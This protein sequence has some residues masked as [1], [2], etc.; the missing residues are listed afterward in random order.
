MAISTEK[1][2]QYYLNLFPG[3][4]WLKCRWLQLGG[5]MQQGVLSMNQRSIGFHPSH[6]LLIYIML[7]SNVPH[8]LTSW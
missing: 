3:L 4:E 8:F 5:F 2:I 7:S 6:R 1:L